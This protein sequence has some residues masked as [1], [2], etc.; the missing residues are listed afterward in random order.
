MTNI[1][2]IAAARQRHEESKQADHPILA[3]LDALALALVDH[4]HTWT[5]K[6][7][8]LYETA[9]NYLCQGKAPAL[10]D[11]LAAAEAREARLL[12]DATRW[13]RAVA[14]CLP[15]HTPETSVEC[16]SHLALADAEQEIARLR[17]ALTA[18]EKPLRAA[19]VAALASAWVAE[20]DRAIELID[21]LEG[22]AP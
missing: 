19:L 10:A 14:A 2:D 4:G 22:N 9:V 20:A 15:G 13:R 8:W 21:A 16:V 18:A 7:H 11:A 17:D 1:F 5:D 3:A 6:E 12:D